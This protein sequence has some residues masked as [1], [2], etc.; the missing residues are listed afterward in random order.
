MDINALVKITSRAWSLPILALLHHGVPARQAPLLANTGAGRTA[1]AASLK[2]LLELGLLERNPGHGHPLRPEFRLTLAGD[3]ASAM[4]A[5]IMDSVPDPEKT[6]VLQKSWSV[7]VLAVT[8]RPSR[9]IDIRTQL[10]PITDRALSQSLTLL[11]DHRWIA[12]DV[13]I[14]QKPPKPMY[15]ATNAGLLISKAI[16]LGTTVQNTGA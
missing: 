16:G 10:G 7:P 1:F 9:F 14:A 12:R 2:H 13:D 15:C 3:I 11:H 6:I 4:A 8:A 5:R